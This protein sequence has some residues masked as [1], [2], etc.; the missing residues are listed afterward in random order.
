M[1]KAKYPYDYLL[2]GVDIHKDNHT[3]VATDCFEQ[4]LLE[5]EF[6]NEIKE[7][8]VVVS[9]IKRLA[10]K[11]NLIPVFG[12]EDSY[13]NGEMLARFLHSSG[14][15]VK[16]INPVL[17]DR[18]R[19]HEVHPEKS[20]P[21][22]AKGVVKV[23]IHKGIDRL[24]TYRITKN[25]EIARDLRTLTNDR[26]YLVKEQT[27]LKN[28]LHGLLHRSYGSYYQV[29]FRD[30]FA[31]RSLAFW[32]AFP[33]LGDLKSTKKK[34][35]KPEWLKKFKVD[36]IPQITSIQQNQIRRK[37]KRLLEIRKELEGIGQ[38]IEALLGENGAYLKSMPGC[39]TTLAAKILTEIKDIKRF[40]S[41][42]KLAKYAGLAP[43][44][45]S[46]GKR[47]KHKKTRRGNRRLNKALY[48]LALSQIGNRGIESAKEYYQKKVNEGKSKKHALTCLKRQLIEIVWCLLK[49]QRVYY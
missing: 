45:S 24:P 46:S 15:E 37:A 38:E 20:D 34:V 21:L 47:K 31:K 33:N 6:A 19:N 9:K 44:E 48:Q 41:P 10:K 43:R 42:A 11:R 25:T 32:Q 28:Q 13:G 35:A 2:A 30:T 18:E 4:V 7:F 36:E 1:Q 22:D 17:V 23:L 26:E 8:R 27:R 14:L 49:E 40:S 12:L 3:V 16:E 29:L 39:G 5:K